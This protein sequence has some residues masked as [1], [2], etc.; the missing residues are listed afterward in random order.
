MQL[1]NLTEQLQQNAA[2]EQY[3]F[4][5]DRQ[6]EVI[7]DL[8]IEQAN[9]LVDTVRD[10]GE[11]R[12]ANRW[13]FA[14]EAVALVHKINQPSELGLLYEYEFP[15]N[16]EPTV[17]EWSDIA[18]IVPVGCVLTPVPMGAE[19]TANNCATAQVFFPLTNSVYG[20]GIFHEIEKFAERVL[21][22][23]AD[24]PSWANHTSITY[25]G[26]PVVGLFLWSDINSP[27]DPNDMKDNRDYY[28]LPC[29]PWVFM[30]ASQ[31]RDLMVII[32]FVDER[33]GAPQ[34][35]VYAELRGQHDLVWVNNPDDNRD[36]GDL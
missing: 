8:T 13:K 5:T 34:F 32:S 35:R 6:L 19:Y 15:E 22:V 1:S 25:G 7:E 17:V 26:T 30:S 4:L 24:P 31:I 36:F 2:Q 28:E 14:V 23:I 27:D 3:V 18:T 9:V 21:T 12:S 11:R 20:V 16:Y 29:E 10:I 33:V